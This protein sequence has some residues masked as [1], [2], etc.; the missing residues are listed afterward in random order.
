MPRS[1]SSSRLR[2]AAIVSRTSLTPAVTADSA[3]KWRSVDDATTLASVVFPVPGGP[4]RMI[5]DSRSAS[6]RARS[7]APGPSRWGWPTISSSVRGRIRAA[8]GA[9]AAS[10]SSSGD[11]GAAGARF[12]G[13]L[14][15]GTRGRLPSAPVPGRTTYSCIR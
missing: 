3:T 2:A 5:D 4:H 12:P 7:G 8:S 14:R 13:A 6:I 10:R 15:A 11:G 1:S 9:W